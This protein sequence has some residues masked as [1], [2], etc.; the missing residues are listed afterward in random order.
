MSW[1]NKLARTHVSSRYDIKIITLGLYTHT[2][3]THTHYTNTLYTYTHTHIHYTHTHYAHTHTYTGTL[4]TYTHTL[5]KHTVM[6]KVGGWVAFHY[7]TTSMCLHDS[8]P[9]LIMLY[10]LTSIHI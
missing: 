10:L 6:P 1:G 3:H 2:L 8:L 5:H 4:H 7:S 9:V